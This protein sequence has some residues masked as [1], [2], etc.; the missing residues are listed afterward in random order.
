MAQA[1]HIPGPSKNYLIKFADKNC[2]LKTQ[3]NT[4]SSIST[5][6]QHRIF[7]EENN[8]RTDIIYIYLIS[9]F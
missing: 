6:G 7:T 3:T 4:Q 1:F 8:I 9:E 2:P 5:I